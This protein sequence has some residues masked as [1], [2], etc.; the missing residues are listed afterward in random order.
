MNWP[1]TA[2]AGGATVSGYRPKT[3]S[4][5][6][7]PLVVTEDDRMKAMWLLRRYTSLTYLRR[8]AALFAN[9]VAGYED[10]SRQ[11][12]TRGD[13]H[14]ENLAS[15]YSYRALL[16]EGLD[17]LEQGY[18]V[19]YASI[20]QGCYFAEYL[21]GQRFE[22][23]LENEEIGFVWNGPPV[24]LYA[25]ADVAMKM[26]TR[27][28]TTLKATW[29]LPAI[30]LS[31]TVPTVLT[32]PTVPEMA[33]SSAAVGTGDDISVSG[34]WRPT[35][36]PW[37]CPNYMWAGSQAPS[38]ERALERLDF[39][40]FPGAKGLEPAHTEY[41]YGREPV[42]WELA[43]EDRRYSGGQQPAAEEAALLGPDTDPPPWPPVQQPLSG[44]R[45]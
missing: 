37:T 23:G 3:T 24:G 30:L 32:I 19:G 4:L 11:A 16:A 33:S 27:A 17:G 18:T 10:F 21:G 41:S 45:P 8:M 7:Q 25:R 20:L 28:S 35:S 1:V 2:P 26:G 9:F 22:F 29:A 15:F 43:W 44:G 40:A 39:P 36:L 6:A 5:A 31:D 12:Q 14:R 42:L 34:I 13:F 38:A